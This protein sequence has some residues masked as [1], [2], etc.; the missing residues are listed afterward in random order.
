M[1]Y[2]LVSYE[3][4]QADHQYMK[5]SLQ[6][7][8]ANLRELVSTMPAAVYSCDRNGSIVYCN[9]HALELWGCELELDSR[10]W[11]FLDSRRLYDSD[12]TRLHP[13]QTPVKQVLA[14]GLPVVNQEFVLE[15]PDSSRIHILANIAPLRDAGGI[16]CGAVNILQDISQIK[17][18][19][20]EREH[21]IHELERSNRELSQFS[22]AVS[23]DLQAPVRRVRALTQLLVR[24]ARE[25]PEDAAHIGALIE[26]AAAGMQRL[27]ES[28]LQYAQ[29]G[30][31]QLNRQ[32]VSVD[33]VIDS[34]R[35]S[36][37]DLIAKTNARVLCRPMPQ[38]E[39][40]PVQ[41]DR[42][43]QNLIANA[44]N[45][46][47]PGESPVIEIRGEYFDEGWRF[48]VTDNGQGIPREY[49]H[50]VFEPLKRL[51]GGNTP[52]SG[53]GLALCQT[54][55]ARHGGKIWVESEGPGHGAS[56]HFTLPRT[57]QQSHAAGQS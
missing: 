24:G 36:L 39:A 8:E 37:S 28:L 49:H 42:V 6:E 35:A 25:T 5:Q 2:S 41:L 12:G 27:I 52:G 1:P 33:A 16:V 14:T 3:A 10:P 31:G 11:S 47:K 38:I 19:Q 29:A 21:L 30:Q 13:E 22:F 7:L 20:Q 44:I 46:R 4:L 15:R 50:A 34:V 57:A 43:F 18:R 32:T 53:L 9:R 26:Q 54:I 48:T 55:V 23:H 40:D 56:F 17:F 51:H 45:Y